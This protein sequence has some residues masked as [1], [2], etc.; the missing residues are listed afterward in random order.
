MITDT[1]GLTPGPRD[2]RCLA[3][4]EGAGDHRLGGESDPVGLQPEHLDLER[5]LQMVHRPP[6]FQRVGQP[7]PEPVHS[8]V[9]PELVDPDPHFV[10]PGA[11]PHRLLDRVGVRVDQLG[12]ELVV[13]GDREAAHGALGIR[14]DQHGHLKRRSGAR[15]K[16]D[17][18]AVAGVLHGREPR[19]AAANASQARE[20]DPLVGP[21]HGRDAREV[22]AHHSGAGAFA[23]QPARLQQHGPGTE[24][25]DGLD[26][27][28]DEEHGPARVRD[29]AHLAQALPLELG[30]ADGED[31]VDEQ[32]L[33]LEVR[34][35][36]ERQPHVHAAGVVLD[37]RVDEP[38][39][40]GE[41]DDLV[42]LARDLRP[43]HAEDRAVEVDVLAPGQ[44][45]V[46]AGADLEQRAD[47]AADRRRGRSVGSVMRERIFSSV[48]LPAPLRPMRPSDLARR[49]SSKRDVAQ[50]PE[51]RR[52]PRCRSAPAQAAPRSG[53]GDG[54]D[55]RVAQ[56]PVALGAGPRR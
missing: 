24:P 11:Q 7:E 32:D 2:N 41:G 3:H 50:R 9:E 27:V 6:L 29:V 5:G 44:L 25:L 23:R 34:R 18:R 1:L 4:A 52:R 28:A 20:V 26:V 17:R 54:V 8:G 12:T 56:R 38:L 31:L 45:G 10:P 37:R 47:P 30:V 19:R 49:A 39:D 15:L 55:E 13:D 46:E 42:E 22:A 21:G 40:L 51:D 14:V 16:P 48:L 36:G 43:A 33:R 53:A 35:D